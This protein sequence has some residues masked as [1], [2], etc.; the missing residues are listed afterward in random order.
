MPGSSCSTR[1]DA[2]ERGATIR[3]AHALRRGAERDGGRLAARRSSGHGDAPER[4][5]ARRALVNAAGP[6]VGDVLQRQSCAATRRAASGWSRAATSSCRSCSSTT[7][8]TSSR[9]PTSAIIFAIPYERDFTLIG[10]TDIDYRRRS[11]RGRDRRRARSTISAASRA[12]TSASPS[13]RPTSSGPIP[14]CGRSTTTAPPRRRR[15]RATMCSSSTRAERRRRCCRV[16]G[17]KITTYRRLAEQ[18]SSKLAPHL[19]DRTRAW[20]A[21]RALPGGDF[22]GRRRRGAGRRALRRDYPVSRR[23]ARAAGS[24]APTARGRAASLGRRARA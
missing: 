21:T 9:T 8:P 6:W 11:R 1:C 15:R 20:T 4:R 17:G 12:A 19:A 22:P 24:S 13:R 23:R 3:P 14:A 16:F 2:A 18:R 10:T 7:A 5:C